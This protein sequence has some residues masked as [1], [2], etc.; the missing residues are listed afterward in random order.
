MTTKPT[1]TGPCTGLFGDHSWTG[2][3]WTATPVPTFVV[4]TDTHLVDP[5]AIHAGEFGSR[6]KQNDRVE[7]ALELAEGA[8]LPSLVH[9]GDLV[10]D[11]PDSES[12]VG[13]LATATAQV[14]RCAPNVHL[15]C[16]NTD[17]GD[18]PDPTSP[19][20][21]ADARTMERYAETAAEPWS[22]FE[23]GGLRG[24]VLA[25]SILNSGSEL[26]Q[27]QWA[28]LDEQFAD[29]R[30]T[31][32]F[33]HY[34]LFLR[35]PDD[36]DLG[37]YDVIAEPAR[38]RLRQLI[39]DH[40]V[41]G[42]FTGH[43]HFWFVQ[44]LGRARAYGINSTSFTRPGFS[45]LFS[46]APPP[47][48]G[49]DDV[50]KLGFVLVRVHPNGLR[51]HRVHSGSTTRLR[52]A[53]HQVRPVVSA[54]SADVPDSGL[55]VVMRH[56]VAGYAE[57]AD[58]FPSVGRQ[59][60]RDDHPVL[61]CLELGARQVSVSDRDTRDPD[62]V[63]RL[64]LLRAEGASV[65]ARVLWPAGELPELPSTEVVDRVELVLLDRVRL[66]T[67]EAGWLA[68]QGRALTAG[69]LH[70]GAK[71]AR[72]LPR[73]RYGFAPA[74]V[75][76]VLADLTAAGVDD[77]VRLTVQAPSPELVDEALATGHAA[78]LDLVHPLQG[79]D[80]ADLDLV[81]DLFC[82]A[83]AGGAG[84]VVDGFTELDRT[85]DLNPGL[86]DRMRNLQPTFHLLRVLNTACHA[87]PR[88]VSRDAQGWLITGDDFAARLLP[89]DARPGAEPGRTRVHLASG[90]VTDGE[91][92]PPSP[93]LVLTE[94]H[95]GGTA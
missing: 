31:V 70:R 5:T 61:A 19:A 40:Q 62:L 35:D 58:T 67:D 76:E 57:I 51:V 37:N 14:R 13:L 66:T 50:D 77:T 39:E 74:E 75:S 29:D 23:V 64:Q 86:L 71:G 22:A 92:M 20:A 21:I 16:G 91:D 78:R 45:E 10:Q 6:L 59:P 26:E 44:D 7:V 60:V 63:G 2:T 84:F 89:S 53:G 93:T 47:D 36:P 11:Y 68:D 41:W 43:S 48:R 80:P 12:H 28:W 42:L 65:T 72:E 27:R 34:P 79:N 1:G 69:C 81:A 4:M 9:L 18:K 88:T 90:M 55:G 49:R 15:A 85:L 54:V 82:R 17:V 46:S 3:G 30:P 87:A 73:W 52:L 24:I 38:T 95:R 56:A 33:W 94:S 25:A 83:T 8:G 32:L